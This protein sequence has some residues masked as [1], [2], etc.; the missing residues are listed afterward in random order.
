MAEQYLPRFLSLQP[1]LTQF[2]TA[3]ATQG[4]LHI[5]P[6]HRYISMRLVL[7]GGFRPEEITPH[8]PIKL[9]SR[10]GRH[11]LQFD[12]AA[13]D[14]RERTVLGGLKSKAVDIVVCKNGV[15]PVLAVS[16]KG[17]GNAFRN[18]TNRM[19]EAIG[20]STNVHIMYPGL[21]YGFLHFLKANRSGEA[22]VAQ[23][24]VSITAEGEPVQS[25]HRYH[26]VLL[27]LAGRRLVRDDYTKYEA[28]ALSLVESTGGAKGTLCR[29]FP[30]PDSPLALHR[31]FNTLFAIYDL[32]FPYIGTS[33]S[34]LRRLEWN[35]RS[36]ALASM[37]EGGVDLD[38]SPRIG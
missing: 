18:L 24:D 25:V 22:G 26:E 10:S 36:L 14:D 11:L 23:N 12:Q 6:L 35:E 28:V 38:Y 13:E 30:P 33:I 20:D 37:A 31:F 9:Q 27:G 21:V 17:T 15:G 7:E 34:S 8:P 3:T 32:R 4:Q 1:A 5:K 2:V 19:E 29:G 16:V